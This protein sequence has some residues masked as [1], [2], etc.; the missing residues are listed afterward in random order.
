MF[1]IILVICEF[2]IVMAARFWF[3]GQPYTVSLAGAIASIMYM[4]WGYWG[5]IHAALAGTGVMDYREI[6]KFTSKGE[7]ISEFDPDLFDRFVDHITVCS[8][9]EIVFHLNCGLSLRERIG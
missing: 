1:G 4:R 2:I 8:R 3:P 5:G 6:L 7:M 9:E